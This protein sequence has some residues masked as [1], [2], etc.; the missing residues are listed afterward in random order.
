MTDESRQLDSLD[1]GA[2]AADGA[3]S[4][5]AVDPATPG[6]LMAPATA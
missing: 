2:P 4:S 5:D 6:E 1:D 3:P